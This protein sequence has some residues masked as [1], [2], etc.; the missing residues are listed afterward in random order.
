MSTSR[1][2]TLKEMEAARAKFL[3]ARGIPVSNVPVSSALVPEV[4]KEAAAAVARKGIKEPAVSNRKK[5]IIEEDEE[6]SEGMTIQDIIKD[7]PSVGEV[8]RFYKEQLNAI[9]EQEVF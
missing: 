5:M 8:R 6:S 4:K 1:S 2:A 7:K 3:G 9:S